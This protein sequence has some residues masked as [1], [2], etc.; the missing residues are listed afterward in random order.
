MADREVPFHIHFEGM[1]LAEAN[2]A[3]S[4]FRATV[5]RAMGPEIR[6]EIVKERDDTQDFGATVILVLGTPAVLTLARTIHSYVIKRGDRIVIT[7]ANGTV[8][9]T[10]TAA[11]NIDV[12]KT[13]AAMLTAFDE[14]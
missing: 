10:G 9:A 7:T 5:E 6:T 12:A 2:Q 4:E 13:T 3:A 1:T 8:V 14:R 11:A